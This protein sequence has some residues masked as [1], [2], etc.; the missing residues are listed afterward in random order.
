[1]RLDSVGTETFICVLANRCLV[2][3]EYMSNGNEKVQYI[4]Q[5]RFSAPHVSQRGLLVLH[6]NVALSKL[7]GPNQI[8]TLVWRSVSTSNYEISLL[9]KGR[10]I[11]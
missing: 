2:V 7:T 1:M 3:A 5:T 4:V 9:G 10:I 8:K 6:S 11:W